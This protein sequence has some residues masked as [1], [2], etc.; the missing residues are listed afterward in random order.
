MID[1]ATYDYFNSPSFKVI[2]STIT[3]VLE[4]AGGNGG[5]FWL[6]AANILIDNCNFVNNQAYIGGVGYFLKNSQIKTTNILITNST[7]YINVAGPTS[8]VFNLGSFSGLEA[9]FSFCNFTGNKGKRK[10]ILY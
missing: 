9:E 7:F 1:P 2:F 10:F 3:R 8:G 5:V 4:I 6:E